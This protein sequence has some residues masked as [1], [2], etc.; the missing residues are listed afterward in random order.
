MDCGRDLIEPAPL[1][2]GLCCHESVPL[3]ESAVAF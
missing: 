2:D 1:D 3:L